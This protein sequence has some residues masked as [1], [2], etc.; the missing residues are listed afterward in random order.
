TTYRFDEFQLDHIAPGS[1]LLRMYARTH[2]E[3]YR[4]AAGVLRAQLGKQPRTAEGGFWHKKIYPDQMWLDGLYM[5]A[6]FYVRYGNL[7]GEPDDTRDALRQFALIRAHCRDPKTGLYYHAWDGR[8]AQKWA[9]PVTGCSPAFWGR[10]MG[11]LMMALVDVL[12]ELPPQAEGRDTLRAMLGDLSAAL[13]KVRDPRTMLWYQV[14]DRPDLQ[15]NYIESSAS[16]MFAYAFARGA[17]RGY[18]AGEY[19]DAAKAS[20][21][22]LTRRMVTVDAEGNVDLHEI[23]AGTGL[24]GNP[25]RDGSP[26]YYAGVPRGTNDIKGYAPMLL[27]AI[28]LEAG[29]GPEV[30][31]QQK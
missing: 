18:L 21:D 7:F 16:A 6:P 22:A 3:R 4:K 14:T 27:A 29:T 8:R 13:L 24:G 30:Q 1:A 11:W 19:R 28:E 25:Y 31:G 20:F 10:S 2:D 12:D 15:G 9:D 26:A 23:A 5:A 17:N